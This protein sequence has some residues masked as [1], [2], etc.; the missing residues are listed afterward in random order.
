[1][2]RIAL[3][4]YS[5]LIGRAL[6]EKLKGRG[7]ETVRLLREELYDLQGSVLPEKLRGCQAVVHLAGAPVLQRWTPKNREVIYKSRIE[8]TSCLVNALDRLSQAERPILFLAVSAIGIYRTGRVHT[9]SS[10]DFDTHFAARLTADWEKASSGLSR[11]IRR[12]IFRTGLVL[13]S[14][15]QLIRLLWFPFMAGLGGAVGKGNQAFPFIHLDDLTEAMVEAIEKESYKGVY[16]LVAPDRKDNR[17]FA[18]ELAAIL[19]RPSWLSIPGIVLKLL[20]GKASVLILES[21][22]VVPERLVREGFIFQYPDLGSALAEIVRRKKAAV[23]GSL[24]SR[25]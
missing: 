3:S 17:R 7:N 13:D 18:R 8:T 20:F 11:D 19:K 14:E 21:P 10:R 12:V 23:P 2:S 1:M 5:G 24:L 25:K 16:N 4:G 15:S 22:E 6:E 9:E